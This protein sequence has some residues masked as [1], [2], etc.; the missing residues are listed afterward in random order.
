MHR[1]PLATIM[2]LVALISCGEST[3]PSNGDRVAEVMIMQNGAEADTVYHLDYLGNFDLGAIGLNSARH[4]LAPSAYTINWSS[5]DASVA[6][7][8]SGHVIASKNGSA[9]IVASSVGIKDSV[10]LEITQVARQAHSRQ[11]TVVALTPGAT[12]LSGTTVDAGVQIPDTVRFA[13]YTTD[14]LG[15]DATSDANITFTNADPSIFTIVPNTKGD[16]VKIIGITAGTGRIAL[17]FLEYTDTIRVQVVS[18]YAVVQL[19][20][21]LPL[22]GISPTNVTIPP[23]SA[24]LFQNGQFGGNFI[25]SGTGWR[26]GPIPGRLREANVFTTAGT[27]SYTVGGTSATVTVAP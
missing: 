23:G 14:R 26:A 9:W 12:K 2:L 27:Y 24:V 7:V 4:E 16:T 19:T 15:T 11:D 1:S 18:S 10:R 13:V 3:P 20:Q 22:V 6:S 21:G 25:V 17:H 8:Q 5:S